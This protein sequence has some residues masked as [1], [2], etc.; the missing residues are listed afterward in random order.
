[1]IRGR[2]GG[3]I[4]ITI[5]VIINVLCLCACTVRIGGVRFYMHTCMYIVCVFVCR[6]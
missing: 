4:I 2:E 1:M 3:L 6:V 5:I